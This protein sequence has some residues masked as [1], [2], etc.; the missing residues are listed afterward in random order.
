MNEVGLMAEGNA[1][2]NQINFIKKLRE[3][4]MEREERFKEFMNEKGKKEIDELTIK[5]ASELI[6]ALK[7]IRNEKEKNAYA[8]GK[9]ISFIENLQKNEKA[10]QITSEFLKSRNKETVNFLTMQEASELIEQLKNIPGM[11]NKNAFRHITEKQIEY[12]KKLL[13]SEEKRKIAYKYLL[14]LNKKNIEDLTSKE[15]S[16][17]IDKL[18]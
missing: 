3:S 12:L 14:G 1:T 11:E 2:K 13:N 15:A 17:L 18:K 10:E 5:E 16:V 4:S 6:E 7:S 8:T 9:Q